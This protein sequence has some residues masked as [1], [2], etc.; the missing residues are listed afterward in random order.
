M[1]YS[2]YIKQENLVENLLEALDL[3]EVKNC[4]I[5]IIINPDYE[6]SP[7]NRD[8]DKEYYFSYFLNFFD[9][10]NFVINC[11]LNN[12]FV[13]NYDS[14]SDIEENEDFVFN[15]KENL[16]QSL[17]ELDENNYD[18][19]ENYS[20]EPDFDTFKLN[21]LRIKSI[22][23]TN[24]KIYYEGGV[25]T[26]S[27][28]IDEEFLFSHIEVKAIKNNNTNFYK[29]LLGESYVLMIEGNTKLSYFLLYSALESYVNFKLENE[30][31]D[32]LKDKISDLYKIEKNAD[33]LSKDIIYSNIFSD[34]NAF[35][36]KRNIIAHGK[37]DITINISE[38]E[39]KFIVVLTY[40]FSIEFDCNNFEEILKK[41]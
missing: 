16:I 2:K 6:I 3:I 20:H 23:N 31:E 38:L 32:R 34:F 30:N 25:F 21:N 27:F 39:K 7:Y 13:F 14:L 22:D 37:N 33:N 15:N 4:V 9:N 10:H 12:Q 26:A 19:L 29:D 5:P 11:Q 24:K 40:I 17:N 1:T 28:H 35:K 36:E 41:I 8:Y 18:L